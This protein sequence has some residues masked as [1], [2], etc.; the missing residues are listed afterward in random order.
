MTYSLF[1]SFFIL[2][3]VFL[4]LFFS[5]KDQKKVVNVV[6]IFLSIILSFKTSQEEYLRILVQ[7]AYTPFF[8]WN[9]FKEKGPLLYIVNEIAY[10][11]YF[12]NLVHLIFITSTLLIQNFVIYRISPYPLLY[13]ALYFSHY[14]YYR[15]VFGI[16]LALSSA[17][18]LL[19]VYWISENRNPIKKILASTFSIASHYVGLVSIIFLLADK[20]FTKKNLLFI[21]VAL[22]LIK[23]FNILDSLFLLA[24]DLGFTLIY[25][26]AESTYHS[27]SI[28]FLNIGFFYHFLFF[29]LATYFFFWS[30]KAYFFELIL[31]THILILMFYIIFMDYSIYF[32]RLSAQISIVQPVLFSYIPLLFIKSNRRPIVLFLFF[33]AILTTWYTFYFSPNNIGELAI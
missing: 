25:N 27:F 21:I 29:L 30:D 7:Q 31:K 10:F 4:D 16:R 13:W 3:L 11:L 12:P 23:S 1:F 9:L 15:E 20:F 24:K 18:F 8:D 28:S 6:L 26:Y 32:F 14:I 22:I 33:I 17:L 2:L 19:L 5:K